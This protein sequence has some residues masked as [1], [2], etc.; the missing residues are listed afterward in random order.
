A[1]VWIGLLAPAG[2]PAAVINKLNSDVERLQQT[3]ELREQMAKQGTDPYR[4]TPAGFAE[5]IRNDV[6]KWGK[7]VQETGL[8]AE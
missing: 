5:L 6:A 2:T 1:V 8:K 3:R 7:I 4:D